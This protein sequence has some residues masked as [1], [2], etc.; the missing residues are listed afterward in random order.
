MKKFKFII[1]TTLFC[2]ASLVKLSAQEISLKSAEQAYQL[3]LESNSDYKNYK[4]NELISEEGYQQSKSYKKA[5]ITGTFNGQKNLDL[6]VT[7]LPGEIFGQP[8]QTVEAQFGQEYTYNAGITI[9]KQIL[10]REAAFQAKISELSVEQAEADTKLFK[11]LLAEQ[12]GL[13]YYTGLIA[14]KAIKLG[15]ED[16]KT[17]LQI[18][19]LAEEKFQEGLL[20]AIAL[21]GAS[22]NVEVVKQNLNSSR[23]LEQQC[24]TELKKL[25]GLE[26]ATRLSF[27]EETEIAIP[28]PIML[29]QLGENSKL[30]L[31]ILSQKQA[32]LQVKLSQ[33]LLLPT[34][35]VSTYH[36]KQQFR[37]EFG[38]GLRGDDW[39]NYS[40]VALN[41]NVPIFTGKRTRSKIKQSKLNQEYVN[42]DKLQTEKSLV[43]SDIQMIEEYQLSIT[44]AESSEKIY[45]LKNTNQEL[46][47]KKYLE[48]LISLDAYLLVY[49][50]YIKA[51]HTYLNALS[52]TYNYY[53]QIT[54]RIEK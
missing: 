42:N 30:A 38:L 34:M 16:L 8:G 15:E 26:P 2:G 37:D 29:D 45:Q 20:D 11:E 17:V 48:G 51:E 40:Y 23:Q 7:P 3:A 43:L 22:I 18:E 35:T 13:Y 6:A 25:I 19:E 5:S 44:D 4:L 27:F 33:S 36:G 12:V 21:N 31:A 14:Q 10:N 28:N 9:S 32:D 41:L 54:S 52:K 24:L 50:E 49:E 53:S 46:S 39:S 1:L 47:L